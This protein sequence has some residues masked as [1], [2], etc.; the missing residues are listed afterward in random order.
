MLS[1]MIILLYTPRFAP[2]V[3]L[4]PLDRYSLTDPVHW[5]ARSKLLDRF[6][7]PVQK[8]PPDS[9]LHYSLLTSLLNVSSKDIELI[10]AGSGYD[11]NNHSTARLWFNVLRHEESGGW[12]LNYNFF[13]A[14][15][16]CQN[17]ILSTAIGGRDE[18]LEFYFCP[19]GLHEGDLE[20]LSLLICPSDER[21]HAAI[22]SQHNHDALYNCTSSPSLC[23]ITDDHINVFSALH[24]HANYPSAFPSTIVAG[25]VHTFHGSSDGIYLVDRVSSEGF[26]WV[27]SPDLLIKLPDL[28]SNSSE[29]DETIEDYWAK[30]P[31]WWGARQQDTP[32]EPS[33]VCLTT[34]SETT[35]KEIP[36]PDNE[37]SGL[38]RQLIGQP[39]YEPGKNDP[40]V[41]PTPSLIDLHEKDSLIE[42]PTNSGRK[43]SRSIIGDS[44]YSTGRG[45]LFR[46]WSSQ[47]W[48]PEDPPPYRT[49]S[50]ANH[51]R[52]EPDRSCPFTM[53]LND[54][55]QF[56][57][58]SSWTVF[59]LVVLLT[60]GL[61][62][63]PLLLILVWLKALSQAARSLPEGNAG[64]DQALLGHEI[65]LTLPSDQSH[66]NNQ[67]QPMAK[68]SSQDTFLLI[69]GCFG[70]L[71]FIFGL[72]MSLAAIEEMVHLPLIL[73]IIGIMVSLPSVAL[74][75]LDLVSYW[76]QSQSHPTSV[77]KVLG[78][79]QFIPH[80]RF[81]LVFLIGSIAIIAVCLEMAVLVGCDSAIQY[82]LGDT[83][84]EVGHRTGSQQ[85]LLTEHRSLVNVVSFTILIVGQVECAVIRVR[86]NVELIMIG[87]AIQTMTQAWPLIKPYK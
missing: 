39:L 37:A 28:S 68:T 15:N 56:N 22:F 44:S 66:L 6:L 62:L 29:E 26:K 75:T 69:V 10:M 53:E 19:T 55:R 14:W 12:I 48:E 59:L 51:W 13:Y 57:A 60:G 78:I 86:A 41:L 4:H 70:S 64:E 36:C 30:Y 83:A 80:F 1:L 61:C 65:S 23:D 21:V 74:S 20:R 33:L 35:M 52:I 47:W 24:S 34:S 32:M 42:D 40:V 17:M 45:P 81:L 46:V 25:L 87:A 16:G 82:V 79:K 50:A 18:S 76:D 7:N 54:G 49:P 2:V 9:D 77:G 38:I 8:D 84:A 31:G 43:D 73:F 72:V 58:D 5:A 3:H 85:P 11:E 71:L 63:P 67:L 27:P